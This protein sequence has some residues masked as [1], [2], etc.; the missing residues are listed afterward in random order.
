MILVFNST[1][2]YSFG[3]DLPIRSHGSYIVNKSDY[4]I[5]VRYKACRHTYHPGKKTNH[6]P[7]FI[8]STSERSI[9]LDGNSSKYIGNYEYIGPLNST[10]DGMKYIITNITNNVTTKTYLNDLESQDPTKPTCSFTERVD[11]DDFDTNT[12][13]CISKFFSGVKI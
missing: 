7:Y 13:F 3:T 12:L 9:A 6:L 8:C 2:I 5:I 10:K 4:P 1:Y 11:I